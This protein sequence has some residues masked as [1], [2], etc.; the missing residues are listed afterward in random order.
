[1]A[2]TTREIVLTG[3]SLQLCVV[4]LVVKYFVLLL[5]LSTKCEVLST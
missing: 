5:L 1:M 2:V 3:Q 4:L